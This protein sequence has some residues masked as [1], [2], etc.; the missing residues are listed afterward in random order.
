[1]KNIS[2]RNH[3]LYLFLVVSLTLQDISISEK[4]HYNIVLH[5]SS[6]VK[7]YNLGLQELPIDINAPPNASLLQPK[8][9]TP[10]FSKNKDVSSKNSPSFFHNLSRFI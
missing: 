6:L 8:K 3:A 4:V 10:Y 2:N 5:H 9:N 7:C 1:M